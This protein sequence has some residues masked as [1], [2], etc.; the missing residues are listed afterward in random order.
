VEG[1]ESALAE[2]R[3]SVAGCRAGP[4]VLQ[5]VVLQTRARARPSGTQQY[6]AVLARDSAS[7]ESELV[8]KFVARPAYPAHTRTVMS[9]GRFGAAGSSTTAIRGNRAFSDH[10]RL[11]QAE[12]VVR[13]SRGPLGRR[14]NAASIGVI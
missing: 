10:R 2:D 12:P 6:P 7:A 13:H 11:E 4:G 8:R 5:F 9:L 1:S 3:S 14:D